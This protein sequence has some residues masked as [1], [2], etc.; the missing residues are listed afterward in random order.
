MIVQSHKASQQQIW[1]SI[2]DGLTS[3]LF[4]LLL[5]YFQCSVHFRGDGQVFKQEAK[6]CQGLVTLV[7]VAFCAVGMLT[8]HKYLPKNHESAQLGIDFDMQMTGVVTNVK[9]IS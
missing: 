6:H 7:L 2:P 5:C 4:L 9:K 1:I 8:S 3:S